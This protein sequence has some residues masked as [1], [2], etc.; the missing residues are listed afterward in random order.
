MLGWTARHP[1]LTAAL[2]FL[3]LLE[4]ANTMQTLKRGLELV[5]GVA[6]HLL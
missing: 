6:G 4:A 1:G 5:A 3:L 2:L